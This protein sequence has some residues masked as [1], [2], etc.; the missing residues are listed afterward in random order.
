VWNIGIFSKGDLDA[1]VAIERQA[2]RHPWSRD[3]FL[4]EITCECALNLVVRG[5]D[6]QYP[7]GVVAYLCSRLIHREMYI[8]KLAVAQNWRRKGVASM[9]LKESFSRALEKAALTAIL[10]VRRS[11]FPAISF[12]HKHGFQVVG[13]RPA[14]Y[15]DTGEDALVMRKKL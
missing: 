7:H 6:T 1:V 3:S 4:K 10:D 12:Y 14:Y 8:L 13:S 2:F 9:L 11:N 15:S 5:D